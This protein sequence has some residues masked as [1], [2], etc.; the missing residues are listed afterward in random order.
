MDHV[1][2]NFDETEPVA[3]FS[4]LDEI[5]KKDVENN[6]LSL[7]K[8]EFFSVTHD[9]TKRAFHPAL[10]ARPTSEII[11]HYTVLRTYLKS[12]RWQIL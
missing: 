7:P 12:C 11:K 3:C 6:K 5:V 10:D 4:S 9:C 2:H 1:C 8:G